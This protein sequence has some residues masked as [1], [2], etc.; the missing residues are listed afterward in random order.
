MSANSEDLDYNPFFLALQSKF[1]KIYERA[2]TELLL[3]CV[4]AAAALPSDDITLQMVETH[5]FKPSPYFKGQFESIS[6][7]PR[8]ISI[9][10]NVL[11]TEDGFDYKATARILSEEQFFNIKY[12]SFRV[13]CI[14]T[15]LNTPP[16]F[17]RRRLDADPF[18]GRTS[19]AGSI[20]AQVILRRTFTALRVTEEYSIH[21]HLFGFFILLIEHIH[22]LN[23]Y[24]SADCMRRIDEDIQKFKKSYVHVAG[25]LDH[26]VTKVD[27]LCE[28]VKSYVLRERMMTKL[29]ADQRLPQVVRDAIECYVIHHTFPKLLSAVAEENAAVDR[30]FAAIIDCHKDASATQLGLPESLNCDLSRPISILLEL[31]RQTTP[32]GKAICA[33][34]YLE[35]TSNAVQAHARRRNAEPV[36]L[37]TDELIQLVV[38]AILKS[39][40]SS[41]PSHLVFMEKFGWMLSRQQE[42]SFNL[43]TIQAAVSWITDQLAAPA[44]AVAPPPLSASV[45]TSAIAFGGSSAVPVP[46]SRVSMDRGMSAS[47]TPTHVATVAAPRNPADSSSTHSLS[48]SFASSLSSSAS[49]TQSIPTTT[50]TGFAAPRPGST[51]E[52]TRS[53]ENNDRRFPAQSGRPAVI[54]VGQAAAQPAPQS[55]SLLSRLS[56]G[57]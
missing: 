33:K 3:V 36:V 7:P 6:K 43:V 39:G 37:A 21:N 31:E 5:V 12:E 55:N 19:T 11:T 47:Y 27:T 34:Q 40:F 10:A 9:L 49:S 23:E 45:P 29:A 46:S 50:S 57:Y 17:D 2:K 48:S 14:D 54:P 20:L 41:L 38:S 44:G 18:A 51:I 28:T 16:K 56:R 15:T 22:F 35:Q 42:L 25:F 53:I 24:T 13:L 52:R 8:T 1:S 4:P 26:L 30:Q 32:F